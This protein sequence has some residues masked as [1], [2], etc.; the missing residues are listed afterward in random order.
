[1]RRRNT[2]A[3]WVCGILGAVFT[4]VAPAAQDTSCISCHG[5]VDLF[6]EELVRIV[7]QWSTGVHAGVDLGCHDCH[8][9]NPDLRLAED[10]EAAM[11]SEFADNP[12]IG[13]PGR[14]EIPGFCGR[15]HSDPDF[16]KGYDPGARV[17]QEREYWTSH[18]GQ[19]LRRGDT[20]V[21]TCI[22]CHGIHGILP[23]ADTQAPVYPKRVAETCGRCHADAERMAGYTLP[24]GRPLPVDQRDRWMQSVHA[25]AMFEKDDLSAPTCNDCHGNHGATP[26]GLKSIAFVCGQ[27]HGRE[28][29]LFRSSGK[30]DGFR[31]HNEYLAE[32]GDD[33]CAACHEPP[34]STVDNVHA[35]SECVTCHA[36]HSVIRPTM[37]MLASAPS[38]PCAFCHEPVGPLAEAVPEPKDRAENY[39]RVYAQLLEEYSDLEGEEL[40]NALVIRAQQLEHHTR[41][42]AADE[43]GRFL[44]PEFERLFTKFRIGTTTY[45]FHDP[46]TDE[47][48]TERV[49]RCSDCHAQ[50]PDGAPT[51]SA[52][53][54]RSMWELTGLIARAERIVLN[55]QRGGVQVRE[56]LDEID[57]AVDAQI[58][59][60]VLV[61]SF[62]ASEGSAFLDKHAEGLRHAEAALIDGQRALEELHFRRIGLAVSLIFIVLVLVGLALKIQQIGGDTGS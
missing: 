62:D 23:A 14:P 53:F 4:G 47:T 33:R 12:Y 36:N 7:E 11:D 29:G 49:V 8:G 18:H 10:P 54:V 51:V 41:A 56:A 37:V 30:R 2:A 13:A 26:P 28:A 55:A 32:A 22:D 6:G 9:G 45:S 57:R 24:D 17:D 25:A 15:C 39:R 27:C 50:P 52:A 31:D 48:V 59:L 46:V 44:R 42:A 1:M 16:M 3:I 34:A 19:A 38:T 58:G 20:N 40:F 35:F 43:K 60:E 21:A 5:N 61:H